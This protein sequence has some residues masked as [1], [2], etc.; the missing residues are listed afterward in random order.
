[1]RKEIPIPV[2]VIVVLVILAIVGGGAY[3]YFTGGSG[4]IP[5]RSKT[6]P[7]D[8]QR[9]LKMQAPGARPPAAGQ[10]PAAPGR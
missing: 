2:V 3:R 5:E 1:M 4:G 9:R 7:P 8:I 6:P 10:M